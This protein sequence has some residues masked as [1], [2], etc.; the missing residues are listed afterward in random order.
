[1]GFW[2][3]FLENDDFIKFFVVEKWVPFLISTCTLYEIFLNHEARY[4]NHFF[5]NTRHIKITIFKS[6]LS[7]CSTFLKNLIKPLLN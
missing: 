5:V 6:K 2:L 7:F 4:L 3:K 1:M